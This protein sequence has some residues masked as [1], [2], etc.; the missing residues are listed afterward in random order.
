MS[1]TI[2]VISFDPQKRERF[3]FHIW[4]QGNESSMS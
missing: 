4:K 3:M 1:G 2:L